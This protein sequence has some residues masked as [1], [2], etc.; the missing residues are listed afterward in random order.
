MVDRTFIFIR[1]VRVPWMTEPMFCP[2]CIRWP[3]MSFTKGGGGDAGEIRV[4]P[5]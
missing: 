3:H 4:Q 1:V 2:R 5:G